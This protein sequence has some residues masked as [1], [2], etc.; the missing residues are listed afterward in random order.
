LV[1]VHASLSQ[2]RLYSISFSY[3]KQMTP[4]A[5][6]IAIQICDLMPLIERAVSSELRR[7]RQYV[8]PSHLVIL[9]ALVRGPCTL[10]GL[11]EISAVSLPTMSH[12]VNTLV[13][14]GWVRRKKSTE[15]R[16][17]IKIELTSKGWKALV[18][19]RKRIERFLTAQ[20][21][22]LQPDQ[23]AELR[24]ALRILLETFKNK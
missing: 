9:A 20:I 16:R 1:E 6:T 19:I 5:R 17:F 7:S 8:N 21:A 2:L 24:P 18:E 14:R 4:S 3:A 15:D 23:R 13:K 22:H 10:S 12:S 11:S